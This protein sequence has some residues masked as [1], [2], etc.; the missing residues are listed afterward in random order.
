MFCLGLIY[1]YNKILGETKKEAEILKNEDLAKRIIGYREEIKKGDLWNILQ[2]KCNIYE[3][4]LK[5]R[6]I[7]LDNYLYTIYK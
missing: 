2:C 4:E 5:D 3:T 1:M 6:H 7:N